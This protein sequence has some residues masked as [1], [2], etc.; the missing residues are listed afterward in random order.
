MMACFMRK[1]G[2]IRVKWKCRV[3]WPTLKQLGRRPKIRRLV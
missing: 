1:I 3:G 2:E